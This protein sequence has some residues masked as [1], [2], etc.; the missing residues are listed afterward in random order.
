MGELR[1][2]VAERW[3]FDR[4]FREQGL[5]PCFTRRITFGD[6]DAETEVNDRFL[7]IEGKREDEP[8]SKGQY[9]TNAARVRNGRTV[10]IVHGDPP[11]D[12][13]Y[14]HR[15]RWKLRGQAGYEDYLRSFK[16][17]RVP[18]TLA[19]LHAFCSHW[20]ERMEAA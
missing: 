18:A 12:V 9:Y 19:D 7:C 1:N 6:L 11:Y 4:G 15:F 16:S 5:G 20:Q 3:D 13:R 10:L 17:D 14:V 2:L 8:L